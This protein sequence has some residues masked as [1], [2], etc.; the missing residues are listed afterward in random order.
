MRFKRFEGERPWPDQV[1][2]FLIIKKHRALGEIGSWPGGFSAIVRAVQSNRIKQVMA[3]VGGAI[4]EWFAV[5][6]I[7]QRALE[8][9]RDECLE[10]FWILAMPAMIDVARQP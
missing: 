6:E 3:I 10:C 5:H 9:F 8:T 4:M 2:P 7:K 1:G